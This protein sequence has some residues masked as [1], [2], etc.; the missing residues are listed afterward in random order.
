MPPRDRGFGARRHS[1]ETLGEI[2]NADRRSPI[3]RSDRHESGSHRANV[4]SSRRSSDPAPSRSSIP[5]RWPPM[6]GCW[7]Q[8]SSRPPCARAAR[9]SSSVSMTPALMAMRTMRLKVA[10][11][12]SSPGDPASNAASF[13]RANTSRSRSASICAAMIAASANRLHFPPARRRGQRGRTDRAD[14]ARDIY[15]PHPMPARR[16][17]DRGRT[18]DPARRRGRR[19]P[20]RAR[21]A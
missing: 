6:W 12:D 16:R 4:R 3:C 9:K 21:G 1:N 15:P 19:A 7:S 2:R 13:T 18:V 17:R 8:P 11:G 5:Q 20:R 10:C 14:V